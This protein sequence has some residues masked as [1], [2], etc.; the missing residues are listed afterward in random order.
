MKKKH[1]MIFLFLLTTVFAACGSSGP[2]P[3]PE[4]PDMTKVGP[5]RTENKTGIVPRPVITAPR[6]DNP[7]IPDTAS[8]PAAMREATA[9]DANT[10]VFDVPVKRNGF[11]AWN[12]NAFASACIVLKKL[13]VQNRW[14]GNFDRIDALTDQTG[15]WMY[16]PLEALYALSGGGSTGHDTIRWFLIAADR[17]DGSTAVTKLGIRFE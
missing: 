16:A 9:V 1:K 2:V 4:T 8:P 3:P 5:V 10:F 11:L 7:S 15:N 17:D 13:D 14:L 12:K 6:D